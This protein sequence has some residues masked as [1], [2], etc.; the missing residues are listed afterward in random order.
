MSL[1]SFFQILYSN[2]IRDWSVILGFTLMHS[3]GSF[4]LRYLLNLSFLAI[5]N[6]M[7]QLFTLL[8]KDATTK[9]TQPSPRQ[10]PA[11]P[12]KS[13]RGGQAF[14]SSF[15]FS[16]SL[17]LGFFFLA[18]SLHLG[19]YDVCACRQRC[20]SVC[21]VSGCSLSSQSD[22]SLA[23]SNTCFLS[24]WSPRLLFVFFSFGPPKSSLPLSRAH[25]H[26]CI[27]IV[28]TYLSIG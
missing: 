2:E 1:T 25:R 12:E 11:L 7:L 17:L 22:L 18:V 6:E 8:G 21:A 26:L 4:A 28:C 15:C 23:S 9:E 24:F 14:S 10:E 20:L 3:S 13:L 19:R 27:C 5:A 16:C